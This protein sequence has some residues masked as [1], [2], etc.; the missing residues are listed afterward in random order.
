MHNTIAFS[1]HERYSSILMYYAC[2]HCCVDYTSAGACTY[3]S[4]NSHIQPLQVMTELT[5]PLMAEVVVQLRDIGLF[6]I[7]IGNVRNDNLGILLSASWICY[8]MPHGKWSPKKI[9]FDPLL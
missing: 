1:L 3:G 6:P 8:L 9:V 5:A 7:D 4:V 2:T